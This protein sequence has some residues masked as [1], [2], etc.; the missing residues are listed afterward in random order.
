M[1]KRLL[2]EAMGAVNPDF[3]QAAI[4]KI[5]GKSDQVSKLIKRFKT[6]AIPALASPWIC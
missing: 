4:E 3:N 1:V 6:N 2:D 5:T